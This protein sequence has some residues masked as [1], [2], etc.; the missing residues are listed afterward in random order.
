M[1]ETVA[2]GNEDVLHQQRG[3]SFLVPKSTECYRDVNLILCPS[4]S[5]NGYL[6]NQNT[7]EVV[8]VVVVLVVVLVV[9]NL[10]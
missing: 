7:Q 9:V 1:Y 4:F 8:V 3:P 5:M 10:A 6:R 2:Q